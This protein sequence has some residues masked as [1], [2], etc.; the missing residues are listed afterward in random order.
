MTTDEVLNWSLWYNWREL[1]KHNQTDMR[2]YFY[3]DIMDEKCT[4]QK[5]VGVRMDLFVIRKGRTQPFALLNI[6]MTLTGSTTTT[7]TTILQ[8]FV[9]DYPG[10]SVPEG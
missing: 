8:P 1:K 6:K 9:Q 10:E 3:S 2:I 4:A 7:T 5:A